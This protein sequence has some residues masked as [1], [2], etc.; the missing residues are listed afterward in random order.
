MTTLFSAG[1]LERKPF[2]NPTIA[3]W[4]YRYVTF[5]EPNIELSYADS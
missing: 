3:C 2:W 5:S 4:V 1:D